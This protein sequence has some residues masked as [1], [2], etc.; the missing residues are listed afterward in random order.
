MEIENMETRIKVGE[1]TDYGLDGLFNDN[2]VLGI[3]QDL[4]N[5]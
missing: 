3:F 2:E 4:I 1:I 5:I